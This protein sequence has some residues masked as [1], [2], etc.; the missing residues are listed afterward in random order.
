LVQELIQLSRVQGA[1]LSETSSEVDL[2]TVIADAVDRN[3]LLAE[4]HSIKLA[5][6]ASPVSR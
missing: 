4:Q 5:A 2:A 6:N 1:K 3:Q